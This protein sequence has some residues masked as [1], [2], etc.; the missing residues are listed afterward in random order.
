MDNSQKQNL[1]LEGQNPG[2]PSEGKG[3]ETPGRDLIIESTSDAIQSPTRTSN[4][5]LQTPKPVIE[6]IG[7]TPG[8]A[9][10]ALAET[11]GFEHGQTSTAD[12][13]RAREDAEEEFA[14]SAGKPQ[15][16]Q[17]QGSAA[18]TQEAK[19]QEAGETNTGRP[20]WPN[21]QQQ[22]ATDSI[23]S[24]HEGESL[25]TGAPDTFGMNIVGRQD[26]TIERERTQASQAEYGSGGLPAVGF[27]AEEDIYEKRE[28]H[29]QSEPSDFDRGIPRMSNIPP[30]E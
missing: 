13:L 4:E 14:R 29:N 25:M 16:Y 1:P 7:Q 12:L 27:D 26:E 21:D 30:E 20:N 6:T 15:Q 10:P 2:G 28:M 9:N 5:R 24:P 3:Y 23:G 17:N 18:S 11:T 22:A 8:A 19:D